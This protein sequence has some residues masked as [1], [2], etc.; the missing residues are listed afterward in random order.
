[1]GV[2]SKTKNNWRPLLHVEIQPLAKNHLNQ[3]V[4]DKITKIQPNSSVSLSEHV[5]PDSGSKSV[6]VPDFKTNSKQSPNIQKHPKKYLKPRQ[7]QKKCSFKKK[8]PPKTSLH[9]KPFTTGQEV[10]PLE[11]IPGPVDTFLANQKSDFTWAPPAPFM[12]PLHPDHVGR[13]KKNITKPL[14]ECIS[15]PGFKDLMQYIGP[16]S[17]K[18]EIQTKNNLNSVRLM[19]KHAEDKGVHELSMGLLANPSLIDSYISDVEGSDSYRPKTILQKIESLKKPLHWLKISSRYPDK[20]YAQG[21]NPGAFDIIQ[22]TLDE[23]CKKLRPYAKAEEGRSANV[24]YM[25]ATKQW[26]SHEDF[27][28]LGAQLDSWAAFYWDFIC[29]QALG[30]KAWVQAC[31]AYQHLLL[32]WLFVGIP[33]PRLKTVANI[34]IEDFKISN[35]IVYL[36]IGVEKNSFRRLGLKDAIG[37]NIFMPG[38]LAVHLKH[39]ISDLLPKFIREVKTTPWIYGNG[40]QIPGKVLG[41]MVSKTCYDICG[42]KLTPLSL[43]KLR[44]TYVMDSIDELDG[45]LVDKLG[46][47]MEYAHASGHSLEV[48]LKYYVIKD[49]AKSIARSKDIIEKTNQEIFGKRG[50]SIEVKNANLPIYLPEENPIYYVQMKKP[51]FSLKGDR[52]HNKKEKESDFPSDIIFDSSDLYSPDEEKHVHMLPINNFSLPQRSC[53]A[54]HNISHMINKTD[55]IQKILS[56]DWLTDCEIFWALFLLKNQYGHVGGLEDTVVMATGLS[57]NLAIEAL[58]VYILHIRGNHWVTVCL[59]D[60]WDGIWVYD[61]LACGHVAED[62]KEQMKHVT[63]EDHFC[64]APTQ[65]QTNTQECGLF[66]IA[67]AVDLVEGFNPCGIQYDESYMRDH[68]ASCIKAEHI[69]P[70]PRRLKKATNAFVVID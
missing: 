2:S 14:D 34:N 22:D 59:G 65:Q 17:S 55:A 38:T 43:R 3:E 28:L 24:K 36:S 52:S 46:L 19:F 69:L 68:F 13:A 26:L 45:T 31:I 67:F 50:I 29:E 25:Q 44:T 56:G 48:M 4:F 32:T 54:R 62:I 1:L 64:L 18:L 12:N 23:K 42:L 16:Y 11:K 10:W 39:W 7:I 20:R 66:A 33:T 9:P 70:F 47:K 6:T 35:D 21:I 30:S 57:Q 8:P 61:S 51:S 5:K 41:R 37:R 58:N 60:A 53:N 27:C 15:V 40:K 49:T 63:N